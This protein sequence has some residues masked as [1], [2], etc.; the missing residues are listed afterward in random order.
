MQLLDEIDERIVLLDGAI[1][2]R[3]NDLTENYQACVDAYNI[4]DRYLDSVREVHQSY[5]DA[6]ADILQ[7]NTFGANRLKLERHG[8]GNQVDEINRAGA[9]MAADVAGETTPVAGSI[10]PL[11]TSSDG[12][13]ELSQSEMTS[14]FE[15]QIQ[16]LL[17]GGIDLIL[18]ETFQNLSEAQA[19]M[20]AAGDLNRPVVFQI[21]GVRQGRTGTGTDVRRIAQRVDQLGADV[22][23][24]NC[25]GPYDILETLK[26]IA[27]VTSAPL[28]AQANAG[29]PEL[30]RGRMVFS[31]APDQ[32]RTYAPRWVNAGAVLIGGCC[33]T[34][35]EYI[36]I[37]RET[38]E[39]QQLAP[40]S[41]TPVSSIRVFE[42]SATGKKTTPVENPVKEVIEEKDDIVI[43]VEMRPS[44]SMTMESY[45][46]GARRLARE[47]ISLFDVP[48][49]AAAKV[50]VDPVV[51]SARLQEETRLPV[52]MHL[53]STHRNLIALQSLLLGMN[54]AGVDGVLAVTGDHPDVG[55]HDKHAEHVTDIKSSVGLMNLMND[56][57]QGRLFNEAEIE[58]PTNFYYG[59]G[60]APGRNMTAQVKWLRQKVDAG[61]KFA[62]SQP[63]Y[64]TRMIRTYLKETEDMDIRRFVGILPIT[65]KGN[66]RFFA[67]GSIP[68]IVVPDDVVKQFE[69][70]ESS[71]DARKL[72]MD[73]TRQMIDET[74]EHLEGLYIIPPFGK[75]KFD[76]VIDI[77]RHTLV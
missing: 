75:N 31:E 43:S 57:N 65:S 12:D 55:D 21:G 22:I 51:A 34:D 10:G 66:A 2:T 27:E 58:E 59:G 3:L 62:F 37:L 36:R 25:R 67:S 4:Q 28:V 6:G 26:S 71:E 29:S 23:G 35:P 41:R 68:G 44:V 11:E 64:S 63:L 72:G 39:D 46:D 16:A 20:A 15:E 77:V 7:S 40:V 76:L 42:E 45:M 50:A 14:V 56:M 24:A 9:E 69:E 18:F 19:A 8:Y 48:D 30:D 1:G 32:F 33:G 52:V 70:T 13:S 47:G 53:G 60:I 74:R 38:V 49:N 73:L 61:A 54:H 17:E 5:L